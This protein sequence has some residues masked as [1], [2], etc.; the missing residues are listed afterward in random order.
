MVMRQLNAFNES[1]NQTSF[2]LVS[3]TLPL[4]P[5]TFTSYNYFKHCLVYLQVSGSDHAFEMEITEEMIEFFSKSEEHRKQRGMKSRLFLAHL[6]LWLMVS[7]CDSC[8]SVMRCVSS[9]IAS[10]DISSLTARWILTK[11][12]RNGPL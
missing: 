6:S 4:S 5:P 12:G 3:S 1:S 2:D 7:Y 11:L 10:K 8:M 9:T